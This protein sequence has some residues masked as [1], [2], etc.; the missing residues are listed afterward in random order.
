MIDTDETPPMTPSYSTGSLR[1]G[2]LEEVLEEYMRRLDRGEVVDRDQF[3]ARHAELA[4]ELR[5]YFAGSDELE[6]LGRPP[7][8]ETASLPP[9]RNLPD[10][11]TLEEA[12]P[13]KGEGRRV[14]DY[15]LL[16]Q[17][18]QGGMGIIYKARQV[19]LQRLVALKMIRPDRLASPA[20]VLRFRSEAEAAASLEHPNI[21]P[22]YEVGEHEGE[23]YFSMKLIEG[24]SLAQHL[25]RLA[26]DLPTGVGM[27]VTVA[28]A[29][30][31]AHQHGVLHRDLKPANVL[32]DVQGRPHVTDFG[33]AK[34]LGHKQAETSLTQQGMI[35]GTPSYMAPEQAASQGGVSTAADVYS[36]GTILYELLTGRPPFR[37]ENL[38]DTLVQLR[39]QEPT[40][41]R[42]L[43]RRVDRDL[44]TVCLKCL[45]KQ[46][47]QRYASAEA[48]AD[49]L[50]RWRRGEPIHARPVGRCAR[51]LK[52]ARR[53]PTLAT[54]SA[55]L[56]VVFLAG[57]VG[58]T[59]QWRDAV[60]GRQRASDIAEAEHRT[61]YARTIGQSY[62]EWLAGNADPGRL[63]SEC[64][65]QSR[66]WEWHYLRRLFGV[67]PLATLSGHADSVLT[68]AFSP[69]GERIASGSADGQIKVWDRRSA[70]EVLTLRGHTATVTVVAFSP[71]GNQLAS[72]SADGN[73]RIWDVARGENVLTWQGHASGVTGL[74]FD[75]G[76]KR[77]A[78][79]GRGEPSPGELKL[80]DVG[81]EEAL[82]SQTWHTLL[83][84]VAFSPDGR[85]LITAC[86]D[87]NVFAWD[88]AT[89]KPIGG[90]KGPKR[91]VQWTSVAFSA[92]GEW[93]AAG[94]AAGFV[95]VWD[96]KTA[97][98]FLNPTGAS[99]SGLAFTSSRDGRP[100]LAAACADYTVRAWFMRSG[101]PAFTLRGHRGAVTAVA[102]SSDG[103]RLVSASRD[104]TVKLWDIRRHYDDLTLP[105]SAGYTSVSFSPAGQYFASAT[106]DNA[107]RIW[108]MTT[109]KVIARLRSLRESVN[110][111]AFSPDGL[112]LACAGS[113]GTVRIREVP[114][115]RE[116]LCLRGHDGSVLTVAFE[117]DGGRLA[118]AGEDGTVRLWELPSGLETL[119]LRGH[120]GT[121]HAVAF[122]PDG[123]RLAS[124][125]KDG[126]V[127]VWDGGTGQ[128]R[129]VLT[130]H[131]G[132]V[133]ALAFSLDGRRLATAGHDEIVRVWDVATGELVQTLSGH[134]G[135][136]RGLAYGPGGRLASAGDD[137]AVRLWDA[138]RHELLALRGHKDV[139]RALAFSWDGHQ[140]ASAGDDRTIKIWDGTPQK[141]ASIPGK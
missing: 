23:H 89:L 115:G 121:V 16:E 37:A 27:L 92:D 55:L 100:I 126:V 5:S 108:D 41:P 118:S 54:L 17:I 110:G 96:G 101:E 90:F 94:S 133:Y 12:T 127:R 107:L 69:D 120:D 46:P 20:D 132:P 128:E 51:S 25:P 56:V 33:L 3:L 74:A 122:S 70:R 47:H 11:C 105:A 10:S 8:K 57:V 72:G 4:D 21:A 26:A 62:A 97:Q 32:L 1:R 139:V 106:R 109:G 136:V 29:V 114:S 61:A 24:G 38:L 7:G 130:N 15:E 6:R 84:A 66:G 39:E 99:V 85:R 52:W 82:A 131:D 103:A 117:P 86:H 137:K 78:S 104:R 18:G 119:C 124:A 87:G 135:A 81:K 138:A 43:N 50:E 53:R 76:G 48:L 67:R 64:D 60:A 63:L 140:L 35:V 75:P 22:I 44:E 45:H 9:C 141:E 19:R 111:L 2:A 28:S 98:E 129:L 112:Q 93:V 77:L 68:V 14:G 95:R 34:R 116:T 30:H 13:A 40:P 42:R 80:W 79:T 58:V 113:D 73:V 102:S 83:A 123:S 65:V 59:W 125:G 36:L 91:L 71:D 31:Y 49:D 134:M 88:T